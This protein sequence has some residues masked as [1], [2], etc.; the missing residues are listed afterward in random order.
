MCAVR[1]LVRVQPP[2]PTITTCN[3][4]EA[5]GHAAAIRSHTAWRPMHA[6]T[7]NQPHAQ[8]ARQRA[9]RCVR[10]TPISS[11]ASS[12]HL[13]L[14]VER[15]GGLHIGDKTAAAAAPVLSLALEPPRD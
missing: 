7:K 13:G 6:A 14:A 4:N 12:R 3:N 10:P 1:A 5:G 15:A 2:Q 8:E 9:A 11:V